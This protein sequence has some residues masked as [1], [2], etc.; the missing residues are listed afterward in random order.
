MI[1]R[2]PLLFIPVDKANKLYKN[3]K[4]TYSTAIQHHKIVFKI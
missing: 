3:T 1:S 4:Y 2:D